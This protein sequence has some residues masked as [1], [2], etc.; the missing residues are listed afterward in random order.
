MTTRQHPGVAPCRRCR[1]RVLF[2]VGADGSV[3][4]LDPDEQGAIAAWEDDT[5]TARCRRTGAGEQLRL[6]EFLFRFHEPFC[7]VVATVT[8]ITSARSLR[9]PRRPASARRTASAR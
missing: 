2:A 1:Q 8:P 4:A 3:H 7:P 6:G 5:G 9:R